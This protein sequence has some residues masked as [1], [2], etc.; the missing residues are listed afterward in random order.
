VL[1]THQN[2]VE[3]DHDHDEDVELLV[4]HDRE[5]ETLYQQLQP[6]QHR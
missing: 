6:E 3:H 2:H 5:E 1:E 4:R